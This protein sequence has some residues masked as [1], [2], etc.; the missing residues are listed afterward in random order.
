[1]L[2]PDVDW[3]RVSVRGDSPSLHI[4]HIKSDSHRSEI[5]M[6]RLVDIPKTFQIGEDADSNPLRRL[7]RRLPLDRDKVI[8][9]TECFK[10]SKGHTITFPPIIKNDKR[11][12]LIGLELLLGVPEIHILTP[13]VFK[14]VTLTPR[15]WCRDEMMTALDNFT[16]FGTAQK[17][18][19]QRLLPMV[20]QL[21]RRLEDV[22]G[23]RPLSEDFIAFPHSWQR[24][25]CESQLVSHQILHIVAIFHHRQ[26]LGSLV[27]LPSKAS[28]FHLIG[29]NI[30][31]SMLIQ[32]LC[33]LLVGG[34][35]QIAVMTAPKPLFNVRVIGL[36]L[37]NPVKPS[38][39]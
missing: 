32:V 16:R 7:V 12:A 38:G 20:W 3:D 9:I 2:V 31:Q 22:L 13:D 15:W 17:S 25:D 4:E 34:L 27:L 35:S 19:F 24:I 29:M 28:K 1:M 5:K 23:R 10:H 21:V 26:L 8:T 11:L 39:N 33:W 36:T 6:L 37:K 30:S 18:S 14:R